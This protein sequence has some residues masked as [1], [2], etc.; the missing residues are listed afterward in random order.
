[1]QNC[2]QHKGGNQYGKTP[3]KCDLDCTG[4]F[5]AGFVQVDIGNNTV[6]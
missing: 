2:R 4:T 6:T 5:H 1:M 3:G